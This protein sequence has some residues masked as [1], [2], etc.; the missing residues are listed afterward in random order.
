MF[1]L[2]RNKTKIKQTQASS[3][4]HLKR[5]LRLGIVNLTYSS[6]VISS[7]KLIY[8]Y[9]TVEFRNQ[10]W[11]E[12]AVVFISCWALCV[13][14]SA[15]EPCCQG[16][17]LLS[18]TSDEFFF[19]LPLFPSLD[20]QQGWQWHL[21][22]S[23]IMGPTRDTPLNAHRREF[24]PPVWWSLLIFLHSWLF[25]LRNVSITPGIWLYITDVQMQHFLIISHKEMYYKSII[26]CR[27]ISPFIKDANTLA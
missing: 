24:P 21:P 23:A 13:L 16:L 6:S 4:L 19:Q 3:G 8:Y 27:Y 14:L 15:W 9:Y 22:P 18:I 17:L 25:H 1:C 12:L 11:A 10:C 5:T 26:W 2:F 7:I 20:I